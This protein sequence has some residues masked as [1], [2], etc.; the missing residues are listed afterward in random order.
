MRSFTPRLANV[1]RPLQHLRPQQFRSFASE[2]KKG[3]TPPRP[4]KTHTKSGIPRDADHGFFD[5]ESEII[6]EDDLPKPAPV[7]E[8][9]VPETTGE[10]IFSGIQP[11][12]VPHLGNYLGALKQWS[13][14]QDTNPDA[15]LI[16]CLVDLHAITKPQ[17]P[18]Q[19]MAWKKESLATLLASGVDPKRATIF[20]QSRVGWWSSFLLPF[21]FH[22]L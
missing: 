3:P 17:D 15:K 14:L 20:E 16:Y 11:T 7:P 10:T 12:G 1:I 13:R 22:Q 19:L 5:R 4:V 9:P 2:T 21:H 8:G 18:K 6:W